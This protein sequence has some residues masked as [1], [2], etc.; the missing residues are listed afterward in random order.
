MKQI[1]IK[2]NNELVRELVDDWLK[3]N[4][5]TNLS[6]YELH[7]LTMKPSHNEITATF[8]EQEDEPK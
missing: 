5:Y 6:S 2:L 3:R 8:R 1:V 4:T 7:T